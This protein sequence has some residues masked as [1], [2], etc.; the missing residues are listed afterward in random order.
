[1]S[2]IS[3]EIKT[4]DEDINRNKFSKSIGTSQNKTNNKPS[5]FGTVNSNFPSNYNSNANKKVNF[6]NLNSPMFESSTPDS[7]VNKKFASSKTRDSL[8]STLDFINSDL[9]GNK[10]K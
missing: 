8:K 6:K 1:M 9:K 10:K 7:F 3:E 5:G 4:I 2:Q